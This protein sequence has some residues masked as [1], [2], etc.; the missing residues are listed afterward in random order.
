LIISGE[1]DT[2]ITKFSEIL[3]S[4]ID[5]LMVTVLPIKDID[6][7]QCRLQKSVSRA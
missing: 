2:V 7:G 4:R 1:E 6:D 5:E 3:D